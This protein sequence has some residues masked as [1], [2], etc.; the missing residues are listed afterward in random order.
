[1]VNRKALCTVVGA[2]M[3]W[4]SMSSVAQAQ[5]E[6]AG[7]SQQAIK[8]CRESASRAGTKCVTKPIRVGAKCKAKQTGFYAV[9]KFEGYWRLGECRSGDLGRLWYLVP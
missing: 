4:G 3:V 7:S 2:V 8:E 9:T 5:V 1:M 6:R